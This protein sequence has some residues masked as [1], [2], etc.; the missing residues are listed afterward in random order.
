MADYAAIIDAID[1]AILNW[2][3]EPVML[4]EAG[5]S[6]TYRSLRDLLAARDKYV[7]LAQAAKNKRAF[8]ITQLKAPGAR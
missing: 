2:V 3:G 8:T 1:A 5:R 4:T 7:S 6:V